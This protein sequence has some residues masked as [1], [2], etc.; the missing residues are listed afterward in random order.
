M[1]RDLR[2]QAIAHHSLTGKVSLLKTGVILRAVSDECVRE[3]SRWVSVIS[4]SFYVFRQVTSRTEILGGL[5]CA[6]E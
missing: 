6:T 4:S 1:S 5:V 2:N 3:Y